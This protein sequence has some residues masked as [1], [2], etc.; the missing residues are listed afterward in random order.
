MLDKCR[1]QT[2]GFTHKNSRLVVMQVYPRVPK[3]T[4]IYK[5]LKTLGL[6]G[7]PIGVPARIASKLVKSAEHLRQ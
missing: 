3:S 7:T 2:Q 6:L 5:S 1:P 4:L